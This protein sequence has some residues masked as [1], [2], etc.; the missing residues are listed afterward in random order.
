MQSTCPVSHQLTQGARKLSL[1][2]SGS[3]FNQAAM[4]DQMGQR[5]FNYAEKNKQQD[6]QHMQIKESLTLLLKVHPGFYPFP[7]GR[8]HWVG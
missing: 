4:S 6:K 2:L 3:W 5:I 7:R 8:T 1:G